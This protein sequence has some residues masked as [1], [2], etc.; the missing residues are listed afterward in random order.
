MGATTFALVGVGRIS[1]KYFEAFDSIPAELAKLV[2]VCDIDP[3]ALKNAPSSTDT[4]L[5]LGRM[6]DQKEFDVLIVCTPSGLHVD[7]SILGLSHL[8]HVL[9]EK[10]LAL[11]RADAMRMI[12][13][14]E[15]R[16][17]ELFV[18]KQN[19]FNEAVLAAHEAFTQ[20]HLG[21]IF[22]ATVRVRWTRRQ[23][24]FDQAAWR[25]TW[26]MDGGVLANQASHHIDLLSWFMGPLEDAQGFQGTFGAAIEAPDTAVAI[27][28]FQ[29]GA[30]GL[31][32]ATTATRPNDLEGS[33]SLLGSKGSVVIGGFAVDRIV[34]WSVPSCPLPTIHEEVS[35]DLDAPPDVYGRGHR[36]VL[37]EVCNALA[38]LENSAI[39]ANEA[40]AA[41]A[42][43]DRLASQARA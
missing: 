31:I 14:S 12:A 37:V 29:S 16:G 9:V 42:I 8:R 26:S 28:K 10:P 1:R 19:R 7:H 30:L 34:E 18:A 32:E 23:E 33:L 24:Y 5:S 17:R 35:G 40:S 4:F 11:T 21:E 43:I 20:G 22:M 38:G 25:G 2:A 6:L 41:V 39:V 15:K 13:E 3:A 36:R 27:L